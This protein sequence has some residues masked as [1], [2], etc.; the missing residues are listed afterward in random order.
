MPVN[1]FVLTIA[2]L[3]PLLAVGQ[4]HFTGAWYG[5][6]EAK[7]GLTYNSYL[8]ELVILKKGNKITGKLNYYF[9][10]DTYSAQ[11][12]G[13]FWPETGTIELLPFK[14]IS[15]F[16]RDSNA[17][18][19]L[20]DGSLTL[21]TYNE[22]SI[23]YGQLNPANEYRYGCP[24][25]TVRLQKERNLPGGARLLAGSRLPEGSSQPNKRTQPPTGPDTTAPPPRLSPDMSALLQR[26]F[27]PGPLIEVDTDSVELHL[28]DNGKV[29]GDTV[30]VFFNRQPLASR[31]AL[32]ATPVVLRLVLQP[33]ENEVAMFAENLGEIPPNTALCLLYAAGRRFDINLTSNMASNGT[34]RVRRRQPAGR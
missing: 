15:F 2:L 10:A 12:S 5:R 26:S 6:A 3:L 32:G 9:G 7:T 11:I 18:D 25:I 29:D 28:Y 8:C 22:D 30:S 4:Y 17:P 20:M 31:V 27:V 1:R 13:T 14:L 34:I 16:A 33:G 24:I 23:L 21:Y 19:C